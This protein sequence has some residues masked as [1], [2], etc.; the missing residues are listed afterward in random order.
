[1]KWKHR[2]VTCCPY[3]FA[4]ITERLPASLS[5]ITLM[6]IKVVVTVIGNKG[7]KVVRV[8]FCFQ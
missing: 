1:M 7:F 4:E 6:L 2:F 3:T 5:A 8:D